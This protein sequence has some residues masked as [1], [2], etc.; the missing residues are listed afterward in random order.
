MLVPNIS[1]DAQSCLNGFWEAA[2]ALAMSGDDENEENNGFSPSCVEYCNA[3]ML[4]FWYA[5]GDRYAELGDDDATP[6]KFGC[7]YFLT[8]ERHGSGFWDVHHRDPEEWRTLCVDVL[9]PRCHAGG[10]FDF[11]VG[12][13]GYIYCMAQHRA[14]G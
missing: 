10:E 6:G 3:R 4:L 12:D 11:Y 9:T 13:D 1:F 5:F 2:A 7:D 8:C 14:E